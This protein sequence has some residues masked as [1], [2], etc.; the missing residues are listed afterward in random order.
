MQKIFLTY[1]ACLQLCVALSANGL[2]G[3]QYESE[4]GMRSEGA[5]QCFGLKPLH[6]QALLAKSRHGIAFSE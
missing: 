6:P 4:Q 3:S 5:R 1:A 2:K